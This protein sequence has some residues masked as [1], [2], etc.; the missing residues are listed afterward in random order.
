LLHS[1]L[2]KCKRKSFVSVAAFL[3]ILLL[4]PALLASQPRSHERA[5]FAI[6]GRAGHLL[7]RIRW[8]AQREGLFTSSVFA[9]HYFSSSLFDFLQRFGNDLATNKRAQR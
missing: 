9:V 6:S 7:H 8:S 1:A 3:S 5:T 4:I 2:A